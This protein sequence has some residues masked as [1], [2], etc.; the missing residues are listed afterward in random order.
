MDLCV[1]IDALD[2]LVY[3]SPIELIID[4]EPLSP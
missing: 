3:V 1:F 4:F 2:S